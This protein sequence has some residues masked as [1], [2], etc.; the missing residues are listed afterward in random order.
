MHYNTTATIKAAPVTARQ[1][2]ILLAL[3]FIAGVVVTTGAWWTVVSMAGHVHQQQIE[4]ARASTSPGEAEIVSR[5]REDGG[6]LFR[7]LD[8]A[9]LTCFSGPGRL[10][11]SMRSPQA[12]R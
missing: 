8:S 6:R 11:M 1:F 12:S 5:C 4:R 3:A 2:S 10:L 7:D 9:R